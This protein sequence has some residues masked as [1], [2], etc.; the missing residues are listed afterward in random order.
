MLLRHP[1]LASLMQRPHT[2][3]T[4]ASKPTEPLTGTAAALDPTIPKKQAVESVTTTWAQQPDRT[5]S[6]PETE[7]TEVAAWVKNALE[8]RQRGT[9][10]NT[11]MPALHAVALDAVAGSPMFEDPSLE[12]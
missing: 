5:F 11:E 3:E 12:M 9:Q 1:W 8:R 4:D 7:D 6:P 10:G 2:P